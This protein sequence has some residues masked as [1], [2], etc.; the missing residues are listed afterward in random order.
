MSLWDILPVEIQDIIVEKSFKLCR[1][2]YLEQNGKK[3]EKKKKK[4]GRGLLTVGMLKYIMS[5]TDAIEMIYWAFPLELIELELLIDPPLDVTVHN[6]DYTEFYDKFLTKAIKYME[7]PINKDEWICPSEDHWL[8]MFTRLVDFHRKHGHIN[9]LKEVDGKP[10]LFVWLEYQKDPEV[11]LSRERR[12]S[13]R[14]LGVR[15]PRIKN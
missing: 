12:D 4:Q 8:C 6:Y 14:S 9:I 7:D 5:S 13:L 2:E 15:L 1:E 11:N 10:S 3:H